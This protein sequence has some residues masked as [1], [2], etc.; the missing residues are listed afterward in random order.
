MKQILMVDFGGILGTPCVVDQKM[1]RDK[2]IDAEK[3]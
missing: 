2:L 3:L 1:M